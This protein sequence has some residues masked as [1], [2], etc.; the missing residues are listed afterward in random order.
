MKEV[1]CGVVFGVKCVCVCLWCWIC[2]CEERSTEVSRKPIIQSAYRPIWL[3]IPL[4]P[5]PFPQ[6]LLFHQS[7]WH[8]SIDPSLL[9]NLLAP[10]F[11]TL[12]FPFGIKNKTMYISLYLA[13][14]FPCRMIIII[15]ILLLNIFVV[16]SVMLPCT[17][18]H[19]VK[20]NDRI[21]TYQETAGYKNEKKFRPYG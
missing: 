10:L 8:S 13:Y 20:P 16:I 4:C 5:W 12:S 1:W 11:P 21:I 19:H 15:T 14:N 9:F 2:W 3:F 7:N 18:T 17:L 6:T